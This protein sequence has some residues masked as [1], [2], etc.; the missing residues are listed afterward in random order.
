LGDL[1]Y[2]N[3]RPC[4]DYVKKAAFEKDGRARWSRHVNNVI[5]FFAQ[6][7]LPDYTVLGGGQAKLVENLPRG[8]EVVDNSKAF[9]AES[10]YG[11]PRPVSDGLSVLHHEVRRPGMR[12][13][14]N[15]A[16][17]GIVAERTIEALRRLKE[18]SV[19]LVLVTGRTLEELLAIFPEVSVFERVVAE[20]GAVLYRP[21]TRDYRILASP[22]TEKFIELL[23][24]RGVHPCQ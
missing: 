9:L 6:A 11:R 5:R 4:S 22:P 17:D 7:I 10:G 1:P 12:L 21:G 18:R 24:Q 15:L 13:R 2:L 8:T 3:G 20:N 14:W 23:K 19:L 16:R